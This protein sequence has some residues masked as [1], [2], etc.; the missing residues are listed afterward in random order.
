[1][2]DMK[3]TISFLSPLSGSFQFGR[4]PRIDRGLPLDQKRRSY[5]WEG[6]LDDLGH[7]PGVPSLRRYNHLACPGATAAE[8]AAVSTQP[9]HG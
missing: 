3:L 2:T 8:K 9:L 7:G 4:D 1:M 6:R 5:I